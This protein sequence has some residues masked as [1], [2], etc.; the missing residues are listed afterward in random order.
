MIIE[1]NDY[2]FFINWWENGRTLKTSLE[3]IESVDNFKSFPSGHSAYA[4]FSVFIFPF[5]IRSKNKSSKNGLILFLC[6]IV[7]WGVTAYSRI[8]IGAHY[9]TDVCFG[10]IITLLSYII[11]IIIM[12][13]VNLVSTNS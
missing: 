1:T 2:N 3:T 10:A 11:A 12:K 9:L 6:G 13:K 7:W 4:M 8:T 5:I